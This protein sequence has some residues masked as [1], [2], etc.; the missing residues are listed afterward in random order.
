MRVS[1]DRAGVNHTDNLFVKKEGGG[2]N[3]K[4][5]HSS[6]EENGKLPLSLTGKYS[7]QA[8]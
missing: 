4:G 3:S 1:R 7:T 6:A 5:N 2:G 8:S